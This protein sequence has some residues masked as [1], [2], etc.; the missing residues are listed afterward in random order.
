MVSEHRNEWAKSDAKTSNDFARIGAQSAILINGGAA[1]ATLAFVGSVAKDASVA[2][3]LIPLLQF[4]LS[5]SMPLEFF[6]LRS[7]S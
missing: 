7:H 3:G 1:A 5:Q 6:L 4:L 2:K